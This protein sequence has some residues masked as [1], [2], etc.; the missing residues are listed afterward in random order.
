MATNENPTQRRF[1]WARGLIKP[2]AAVV[3]IH[4][5]ITAGW[6]LYHARFSGPN[7]RQVV[8]RDGNPYRGLYRWVVEDLTARLVPAARP[9]EALSPRL[10]AEH[11]WPQGLALGVIIPSV[12]LIF[13]LY[14]RE[15]AV[16]NWYKWLLASVRVLLVLLAMFMLSEMVLS[17]ERTGLPYFLVLADDSA[18]AEVA[19]VFETPKEQQTAADLAKVSGQAKASRLAVAQG[20]LLKDNAQL[21]REL[22]KQHKV[23]L[24]LVSTGARPLAEIDQANDVKTAV[25][26]LRKVEA[27]EEQTRL[28]DSL[29]QVLTEL[30][31]APPTAVLLFSDGQT[32]DGE[33]LAKSA[34]L[35]RQRGV[36]VFTV[37]LGDARPAR[38]LEL[39]DL[40]VEDVVFVDDAVKFEARLASR[41][42]AGEKVNVR[43]LRRRSDSADPNSLE[44]LESQVVTAPPDGQSGRVEIVYRPKETG[45][46]IFTL[47]VEPKPRELQTD[48]NRISKSVIVREERLRVLLVDGEPRYEY[49][50]LKNFLEREKSVELRA[51]LQSSDPEYA[52]Q[53]LF[54]LPTFPRETEGENGLF[55]FD[56]VILGDV[57]PSFLNASQMNQLS[58]FV[59]KRGGGLMFVAGENFNPLAYKRTPLEPLLPILLTDARNPTAS[60]Q[61]IGAFRPVLTIEGRGHPIFRFGDTDAQ[62]REIWSL[63]P[64]LQWFLEAPRKQPTAFVLAEHPQLGG[65]EGKFPIMMYHYVGSGKV[66]LN[67]AD[68]TW[69]WRFR[70]GDRYFGR[71]WTQ[72]IRFLARSRLLGQKQAEISTDR[73][74]YLRNQA[75]VVQVRFVNPGL[76]PTT[77]DVAVELRRKGQGPRRLTLKSSPGAKNT[78]E[79][80]LPPQAEGEYEAQLL[81]PPTLTSTYPS[82]NFRVD[83]PAGEFEHISM[84]EPE[85][86]RAAE[87]SGGKFYTPDTLGAIWKDLPVPQKVP[88]DTDPP[89]PLWNTWPVLALFLGLITLEW[90]LR[91]RKQMV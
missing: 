82:T 19:D 1:S 29:R 3:L 75:I 54:A 64:E 90:V 58:E 7:W 35:A 71:Y 45:E 84:N 5:I 28:G 6:Y 11:P 9:G 4:L 41:G 72:T 43:L 76:A 27:K 52:E 68:D 66:M 61:G 34:E 83:P 44:P 16:A 24:Y 23:K 2:V 13:W 59:T 22:Q 77:G 31:G 56:V 60:G 32:T 70:A 48:N 15:G 47:E 79:T 50:F 40:Q 30:R 63:L 42:F 53:D 25:A 69:R 8:A 26:A 49:R 20:L 73:K 10:R 33:P 12:I 88:L 81:P 46:H 51:V 36:P 38:D 78:F 65:P 62:S 14:R 17:V 37:G 67:T 80:A 87:I 18:S 89:V 86:R 21:I 91:K 74:R 85:L 55:S 57:D 39:T